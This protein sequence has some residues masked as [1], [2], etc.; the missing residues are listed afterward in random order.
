MSEP[1]SEVQF[2]LESTIKAANELEKDI[3]NRQLITRPFDQHPF[4][5]VACE[6]LAK[7]FALSRSAILL[8]EHGFSDEAFGLCRSIYE[9]AM[10]LRYITRDSSKLDERALAFLKFGRDSKAFWLH[11]LKD[12]AA[13]TPDELK[14]ME[15][16]A[17]DNEIPTD[18]KI[19]M[20]PWSGVKDMIRTTSQE[21]HPLDAPA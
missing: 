9:S 13:L 10:Y 5:I 15:D 11:I 19:M 18:P 2:S 20:R 1:S 3:N 12:S 21:S 7:A 14:E 16:Y 8:V 17:A 6:L 4:D